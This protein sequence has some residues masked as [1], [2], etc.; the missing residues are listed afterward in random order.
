MSRGTRNPRR[1][2]ARND[3][4][5]PRRS[6]HRHLRELPRLRH[7]HA[8][9][10]A[11]VRP[12]PPVRGLHDRQHLRLPHQP[13]RHHRA[14]GAEEDREPTSSSTT[15]SAR[16]SVRSSAPGSIA[17]IIS[18]GELTGDPRLDVSRQALFSGASNG[19]GDHSPGSASRSRP[20]IITEIVMTAIFVL[21]I[22]S[23]SRKSM[24]VGL[25][26][27]HRRP[28]A[29]PR[30]HDQ[31]PDRQHV[32]EPRSLARHRDLRRLVGTGATLG[33]HHLPDHRRPDRRR[34][35]DGARRP[36]TTRRRRADSS[37]HRP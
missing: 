15:S 23:T 25:H 1:R 6:R 27:P 17:L 33:V 26:R 8:R 2:G 11:R 21:V 35:L 24:P 16:S 4:P 19:Y 37:T 18:T 31:H 20:S 13:R 29:R 5:H 7:R 14:L 9:R 22:A 28:H 32:G 30:A 12:Q 3:D 10:R 36:P 34:H